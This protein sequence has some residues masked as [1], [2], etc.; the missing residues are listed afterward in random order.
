MPKGNKTPLRSAAVAPAVT[1][2]MLGA[3]P[4]P[5]ERRDG[6]IHVFAGED[7]IEIWWMPPDPPQ[8]ALEDW[9]R[10]RETASSARKEQNP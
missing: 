7:Q 1:F 2:V 10:S 6:E 9:R 5:P 4:L 3:I 8:A